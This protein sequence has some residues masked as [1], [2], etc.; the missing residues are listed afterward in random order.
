M[1]DIE[2]LKKD[3]LENHNK[4]KTTYFQEKYCIS[5]VTVWRTKN[6]LGLCR[7]RIKPCGMK[8]LEPILEKEYFEKR[9]NLRNL[10]KE[11]GLT[12]ETVR[13]II[14][15]C[16]KPLRG[17]EFNN[18]KYTVDETFFE[19]IDSPEKAYWF[20]F[21]AA[22]GNIF[23]SALQIGLHIKDKHHL[24]K[25]SKRM[26]FSGP[27]S[28]KKENKCLFYLN[29]KKVV[30]DLKNLGLTENKT[31]KIDNHIFDKVPNEFLNAAIH[32]YFDGDGCISY[33]KY[34]SLK[35]SQKQSLTLR[36]TLPGNP[37]F[38]FFIKE[39]F[40]KYG[41]NLPNPYFLKHTKQ[42]YNIAT[43][44]SESRID[45]INKALFSNPS[46]DFLPR[47]KNKLIQ[48]EKE[49]KDMIWENY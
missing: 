45:L 30:D 11:Y 23:G 28:P 38:L 49:G 42:T 18:R 41:V 4:Y 31:F 20:G 32:G 3:L 13:R 29:R 34:T 47:K 9:K 39:F 37:S 24:E 48:F 17:L 43:T 16:G 46:K 22:D 35:D 15:R 21:I 2:A 27:I 10:A 6:Q 7:K 1:A 5:Q 36:F 12:F 14:H 26:N 40:S 44:I 8:A 25:I 33:K 19:K